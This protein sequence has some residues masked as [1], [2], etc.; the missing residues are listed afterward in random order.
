MGAGYTPEGWRTVLR[1][2]ANHGVAVPADQVAPLN[3]YLTKSFP[4]KGK[5]A[6]VVTPGPAEVSIKEWQVPTP[7]SRP[8]DPLATRDGSLWYTGQMANV[9]G[10][11]DQ[12]TGKFKEYQLKTP[13]SGPHGLRRIKT[14]TF[15]TPETPDR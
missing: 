3:E 9:L 5:P 6:G 10:Q 11:L 8:H 12:K 4:E 7:G 2:M 14:A 1:M 13:H 15:G